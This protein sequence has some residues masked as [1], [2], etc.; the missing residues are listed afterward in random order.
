M[1]SGKQ[2]REMARSNAVEVTL[3]SGRTLVIYSPDQVG[4]SPGGDLVALASGSSIECFDSDEIVSVGVAKIDPNVEML[5]RGEVP[6]WMMHNMRQ[7]PELFV[8]A[9]KLEPEDLARVLDR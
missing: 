4:S 1:I 7:H 9:A 8:E 2:I 3:T 5:R 6:A